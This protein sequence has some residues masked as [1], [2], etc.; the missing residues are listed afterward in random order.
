MPDAKS[1]EGSPRPMLRKRILRKPGEPLSG[2]HY[3]AQLERTPP[4]PATPPPAERTPTSA[5]PERPAPAER[6]PAERA[7]AAEPR[8]DRPERP[9]PRPGSRLD[10]LYRMPMAQLFKLAE[11]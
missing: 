4:A 1:V 10:D 3:P 6:A 8:A 2:P 9:A 5:P 7:P 11:K